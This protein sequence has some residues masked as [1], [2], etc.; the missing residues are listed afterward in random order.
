MSLLREPDAEPLPGYRLIEPL[1][2]GGFGEVWKCEAPGGILKAIKFVFGNL[3]GMD[4]DAAKAEQEARALERVKLIRHPF[5]ISMDLIKVVAGELLMVMELADNSLHEVFEE[6][7]LQGRPGIPRDMLLGFLSDAAEGLDHLIEKHNLQHLDVKPKNLFLI[8]DRVKVADFGL[9]RGVG[10]GSGMMGGITPVYAAPETFANKISKHSDQYSLAVVYVDLLTGHKPFNGKNIRQLAMQHMM[11]PPDLSAVPEPDRSILR[12]ALSKNPDERFPNCTAFVRALMGNATDPSGTLAMPATAG[13]GAAHT[14]SGLPKA[15]LSQN[16]SNLLLVTPGTRPTTAKPTAPPVTKKAMMRFPGGVISPANQT[17][18]GSLN[19]AS[20]TGVIRPALLIGVGS[21]GRRALQQ[22][23]CRLLDR[24][25]Q[26]SQVPCLRYLYVDPDPSAAEKAASAGSDV[27]LSSEQVFATPLQPVT[28]YRRRQID[29][30]TQWLP[31]EKL[32]S[33]PRS[34]RV[35][36]SRAL[37]RLA[38]CDH[39][40]RFSNR[41]K[42]EIGVCTSPEAVHQSAS[43]TGQA[44][45]TKEPAV[46]IFISASGGTSG[47]LLDLGHAVRRTLDKLNLGDAPVTAFVLMGAVN[48]PES[49]AEELANVFATLTELNHYADA[50]VPFSA[51]YGGPE[52]PQVDARGLPFAATYLLP[53]SARTPDAFRDATSHLAGYITYDLTTP[54]GGGLDA[55]R[56]KPTPPGRTPFRG[57]GT[58]GVW[59]PRGLLLRSA[60]RQSCIDLLRTWADAP[61]ALTGEAETTLRDIMGD[62][63]L[64][65]EPLKKF[66]VQQSTDADGD[67][68]A[69]LAAWVLDAVKLGDAGGPKGDPVGWAVGV[70]DSARDWL[71]MEP[72]T[73]ADSGFRRGR[74]SRTLDAGLRRASEAWDDQLTQR[75]KKLEHMPGPRL[76]SAEVVLAKLVQTASGAITSMETQLSDLNWKREAAKV[77]VQ[78]AVTAAQGGGSFSLFGNRTGKSVKGVVDAVRGFVDLRVAEDLTAAALQFYRRLHARFDEWHRTVQSARGRLLQLTELMEVPILLS[79]GNAPS[80]HDAEEG[81]QTTLRGSNTM[82]VVLPKGQEQ[83]DRSASDLLDGLNAKAMANLEAMLTTV[84]LE[85]R[86][87]LTHLCTGTADLDR[88][89]AAPLIDQAT[90]FLADLLPTEDVTNVELSSSRGDQSELSR[91]VA[92]YIR[93]AAPLTGGPVEE[94]RTFLVHPDTDPGRAYAAV[95]KEACPKVYAVPVKGSGTDLLFCREQPGLRM[96]DLFRLIDPC[97]DAYQSLAESPLHNPHA[98]FD[99][100]EWLPLVE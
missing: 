77:A 46:Y 63:R 51:R 72:T 42:H 40:L 92:S 80:H 87:G 57:F 37:G 19:F 76:G 31:R 3:N 100:A 29:D 88:Q 9:V 99:V 20:E 12:R 48:D 52:G 78:D 67:P 5:V 1:G 94:E 15:G 35:D 82:R 41:L 17:L 6:Y 36:G 21:F 47:M 43:F 59:Y 11:E 71:G 44:V 79:A 39:Y 91:R 32:Y 38:F 98:R 24:L 61:H 64:T 86:G 45:R 90:A 81:T 7:K 25:G 66:I 49:P 69:A 54:L 33:I 55:L 34:L 4:D 95:V 22:I 89:L 18:S 68:L 8:A 58:F 56:A 28:N 97:W 73:D 84:V 83:L 2:S 85:P 13:K 10:G 27:S 65:P 26:L 30:L 14:P 74:L 16:G 23:R 75:V 62:A 70:W 96:A 50:D 60:A 53:M 93:G